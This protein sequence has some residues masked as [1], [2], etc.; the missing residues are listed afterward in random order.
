MFK[1]V[2][3]KKERNNEKNVKKERK[4]K[5]LHVCEKKKNDIYVWNPQKN[6]RNAEI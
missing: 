1:L 2:A 6:V 5:E 3:G 4:I